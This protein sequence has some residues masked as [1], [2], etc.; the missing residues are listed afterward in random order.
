MVF[1]EIKNEKQNRSTRSNFF[2]IFFYCWSYIFFNYM[3]QIIYV[4][5]LQLIENILKKKLRKLVELLAIND[6]KIHSTT[7]ILRK[8][9]NFFWTDKIFFYDRTKYF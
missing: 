5:I 7:F 3:F 8:F 1:E 9:F 6:E 4:C 2:F